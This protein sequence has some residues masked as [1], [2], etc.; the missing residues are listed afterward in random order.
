MS[1]I[2]VIQSGFKSGNDSELI[3]FKF[4]EPCLKSALKRWL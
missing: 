3:C 4:D 1:R 2:A